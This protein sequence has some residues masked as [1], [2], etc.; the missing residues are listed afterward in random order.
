MV[1]EGDARLATAGTGDV[2]SGIIGALLAQGRRRRST[3]R[4]PA[5][6]CTPGPAPP[7]RR[8]AGGRP[9]WSTRCPT[10][11]TELRALMAP[12]RGRTC[13]LDAIAA[14][15]ETLAIGG[16]PGRGVRGGEG[17]RLR[18]RRR[19]GGTG[20]RRGRRRAGSPWPRCPRPPS[21][22]PPASPRRSCCCRSR[23]LGERGRGPRRGR[24]GHRVH[25]AA[26]SAP[27]VGAAR[28]ARCRCRSTSRSTPGCAAS[29][30]RPR[31]SC[32]LAERRARPSRAS[33]STGS[34][35]TAPSPTSPTT[36]SPP[37]SSS[38][39]TPRSRPWRRP[40]MR[41]PLRH[42]ANSAAAIAHPASRYDLV[43]CGIAV[44]GIAARPGARRSRWPW[45]RPCGSPPR[46]PS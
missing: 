2:L 40:G 21:C 30:P 10:R 13:R 14:N 22:A 24:R 44:Y 32:A 37:S 38:G 29:A 18:P 9:T 43:R 26:R 45:S 1:A 20:R 4:P 42:A 33:R 17:R 36:R 6:G 12:A 19:A 5:P 23:A 7:A 39:S 15:V 11:S 35:P 34:G 31:P 3:R 46:S 41:V 27:G 16:A 25:R 8:R 28:A